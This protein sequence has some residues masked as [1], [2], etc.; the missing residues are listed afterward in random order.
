MINKALSFLRDQLNSVLSPQGPPDNLLLTSL[1]NE[2]G[3]LNIQ[4]A[5]M[6]LML[7]NAEEE[8]VLK[9]QAPRERKVGDKVQFA[10]PEIKLNLLVMLAANPGT[11]NY[12]D[13]L[14]RL[15]QAMI[16]FQGTSFFDRIKF[17][18]LKLPPEIEQL[19]VELFTLSL[20]Q[21]NQLWGS[22]GAKYIPSV[23]YKVRLVIIDRGQFGD[24]IP[25]IK[26]LDNSLQRI[27]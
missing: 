20:E 18:E 2:R 9:A 4:P 8:R 11:D 14:E 22:L 26:V 21:Q 7:V 3:E 19:S 17:P 23:L 13:A 24:N 15:S 16:F 27:N 12:L 6:A 1:V 5:Q 10:N 25:V